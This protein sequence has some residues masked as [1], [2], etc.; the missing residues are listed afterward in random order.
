MP[1][2]EK[3]CY[4]LVQDSATWQDGIRICQNIDIDSNV[5][6]AIIK[7]KEEDDFVKKYL[8]KK[9]VIKNVWIGAKRDNE[10][11]DFRLDFLK[12][13]QNLC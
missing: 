5:T 7:S 12:N 6:I 8:N 4:L 3:K 11:S 2:D 9:R 10:S 13:E 1:W